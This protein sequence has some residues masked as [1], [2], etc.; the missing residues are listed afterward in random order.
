MC[1]LWHRAALTA[2]LDTPACFVNDEDPDV[3]TPKLTAKPL[4]PCGSEY[5]CRLH[6]VFNKEVQFSI[7][8]SAGQP[9]G[10]C[11]LGSSNKPLAE[12]IELGLQAVD[13]LS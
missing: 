3:G 9:H 13:C 12:L 1:Q 5:S 8:S 7:L 11:K 6:L 2:H 4:R 10:E